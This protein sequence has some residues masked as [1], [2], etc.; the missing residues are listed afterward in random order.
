MGW[1]RSSKCLRRFH[2]SLVAHIEGLFLSFQTTVC[3]LENWLVERFLL[4]EAVSVRSS[5]LIGVLIRLGSP[6]VAIPQLPVAFVARGE[7][8]GSWLYDESRTIFKRCVW[9][10]AP[11]VWF[12]MYGGT[13]EACPCSCSEVID[14]L[15]VG[16]CIHHGSCAVTA[17]GCVQGSISCWDKAGIES[18]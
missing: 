10:P 8:V 7:S 18:R 14:W 2:R 5:I 13:L 17:T 4:V 16:C 12:V 9:F 15:V 3:N 11:E 6:V 1:R